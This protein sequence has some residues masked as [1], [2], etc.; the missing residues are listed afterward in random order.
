MERRTTA[1]GVGYLGWRTF[2]RL[3]GL[4]KCVVEGVIGRIENERKKRGTKW[5]EIRVSGGS[6]PIL[7]LYPQKQQ[8]KE[9]EHFE[10]NIKNNFL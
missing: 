9:E 7:L 3:L 1:K 10:Y 4:T 6:R 2:A 5:L 8:P